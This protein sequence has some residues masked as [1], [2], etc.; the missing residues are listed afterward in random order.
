MY[1]RGKLII[2][3]KAILPLLKQKSMCFAL[4]FLMES[5]VTKSYFRNKT[6][7]IKR[8]PGEEAIPAAQST[9]LI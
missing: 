4:S 6:E 5:I 8:A 9:A 7:I 1:K 3:R 2:I